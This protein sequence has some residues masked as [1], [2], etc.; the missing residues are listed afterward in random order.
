[1]K[2]F[3]EWL[4]TIEESKMINEY[5]WEN[6]PPD[7]PPEFSGTRVLGEDEDDPYSLEVD[8]ADGS[9]EALGGFWVRNRLQDG[10][11]PAISKPQFFVAGQKDQNGR[12]IEHTGTDFLNPGKHLEHLPEPLKSQ[13]I[14]W[15]NGEVG[16]ITQNYDP[17]DDGPDY[18]RDD[19]NPDP[20][21]HGYWDRYWSTGPGRDR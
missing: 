11:E 15:V 14:K 8:I 4:K 20:D 5:W 12:N 9:W 16:R 6:G 10:S 2:T 1:M 17:R 18:D 3:L 19:Y 21:G 13:A 7:D